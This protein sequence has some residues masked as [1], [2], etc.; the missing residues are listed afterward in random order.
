MR[1]G[2]DRR[3]IALAALAAMAGCSRPSELE[4][5]ITPGATDAPATAVPVTLGP[6]PPETLIVCLGSEPESLYRF[7]AEYLYGPTSRESE[8]VLQALYDGPLDVVGYAYQPVIL[9]SL[10]SLEAGDARLVEISLREPEVYFNP[11]TMQPDSLQ[12]GKPFL[13]SGCQDF[14]CVRTFAGGAVM[15][16]AMQVDFRLRPGLSWSDGRPLTAQDSVFAFNLD[17]HRDTPTP[18]TLVDR[19][20]SYAAVDELTIRWSGIPGYMDAEYYANLWSPLPAHALAGLTPAE[21][22][23]APEANRA[24][25]G[26]GPYQMESWT[27]GSEISLIP[28]PSYFRAQEGLPFFD[29]LIFRFIGPQTQSGIDQLLTGE[30]DLL[31]ESAVV[32]ALAVDSLDVEALSRLVGLQ[33]AGGIALSWGASSEMERLDFNLTPDGGAPAIFADPRTRQAVAACLDRQGL[34]RDLLFGLSEVPSGYLPPGHP[35]LESPA[36]EPVGVGEGIRLLEEVG[37]LDD[38]GANATARVAAGVPGVA[39]G[40]PLQFDLLIS[41]GA[42]HRAVGER[43]QADLARCGMQVEVAVLTTEQL[44][45]GW[46]EGE[47]FGRSF[48]S[49]Q[50]AWPAWV[51]PLCEMFAGFEIPGSERPLGINATGFRDSEYDAACGRL[52]LGS[53]ADPGYASAVQQTQRIFHEQLP[54]IPLY[55]RPRVVAYADGLCGPSVEGSALTPLWNLEQFSRGG[56]C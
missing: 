35:L 24:P 42:L 41:S 12:V 38:D 52:L 26:W 7:S 28:N 33:A 11:Q 1:M 3:T 18:K 14:S 6:P 19:T 9:Q 40:T 45:Q 10:P 17:R 39:G 55:M 50:W 27:P 29:R 49:V 51:S 54:A 25:L 46:P 23:S 44:F 43:I 8:A 48:Q 31:D 20:A 56:D 30:C 5:P 53:P 13:P 4:L 2:A 47:V 37:W 15:M 22:L 34:V 21:L 16:Q 36:G 32:E